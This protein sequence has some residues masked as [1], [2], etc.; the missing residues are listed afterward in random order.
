[1]YI[2]TSYLVIYN[3]EVHNAMNSIIMN[4]NTYEYINL[5]DWSE[6][7][8]KLVWR[9]QRLTRGHTWNLLGCSSWKTTPSFAAQRRDT[10]NRHAETKRM[11]TSVTR[12]GAG[13][14]RNVNL[15]SAPCVTRCNFSLVL[16][17]NDIG[18]AKTIFSNKVFDHSSISVGRKATS[19]HYGGLL[20][21][22]PFVLPG[23]YMS[24]CL[25]Q[26]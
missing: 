26:I 9:G 21:A 20:Y 2:F 12:S 7:I 23:T 6:C 14:G 16:L 8:T 22:P 25:S 1:M 5:V 18:P 10:A 11:W 13:E 24:A 4:M 15:L 3:L 17:W 19:R